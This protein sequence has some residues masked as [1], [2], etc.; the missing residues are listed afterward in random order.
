V[1]N[2]EHLFEY[3]SR[4]YFLDSGGRTSYNPPCTFVVA[5]KELDVD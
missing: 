5:K 2:R 1:R 4:T 3:A